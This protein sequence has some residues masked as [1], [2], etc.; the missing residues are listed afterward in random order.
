ML[1]LAFFW[2]KTMLLNIKLHIFASVF[3]VLVF[4]VNKNLS[5]RDDDKV[6]SLLRF[7]L[8]VLKG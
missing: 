7:M 8:M 4:K 3:M 6:F 5:R 1:N 2:P